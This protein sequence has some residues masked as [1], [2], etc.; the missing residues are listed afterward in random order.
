MSNILTYRKTLKHKKGAKKVLN[1]KTEIHTYRDES[2][3]QVTT[4]KK[5]REL[6]DVSNSSEN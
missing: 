5:Y 2:G 3:N 4:V 6:K 1:I